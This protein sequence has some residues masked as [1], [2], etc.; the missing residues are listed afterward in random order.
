MK[1]FI[2]GYIK[3]PQR[4]EKLWKFLSRH[5][6][7]RDFV[8]AKQEAKLEL[9]LTEPSMAEAVKRV[10]STVNKTYGGRTKCGSGHDKRR[11]QRKKNSRKEKGR[12]KNTSIRISV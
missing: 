11:P 8:I 6:E 2:P 3:K 4:Q 9:F 10:C 7:K 5:K 12:L 1:Q